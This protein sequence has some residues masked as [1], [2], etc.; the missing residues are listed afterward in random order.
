MKNILK[1]VWLTSLSVVLLTAGMNSNEVLF[2]PWGEQENEVKHEAYPGLHNGP[3]SFQVNGDDIYILDSENKMIKSFNNNSYKASMKIEDPFILDFY[4]DVDKVYLMQQDQVYVIDN[5]KKEQIAKL[6]DS[7]RMYLGLINDRGNIVVKNAEAK[8][9]LTSNILAKRS[10]TDVSVTR[11]LPSS[12]K[13]NIAGNEFVYDLGE[14]GSVDVIG[15]T[16]QGINYI[17]AESIIESSPLKVQRYILLIDNKGKLLQ[18]LELPRQKY[19]YVFKEFF[20]GQEG[21]L[22]HMHSAKDGIHII[23]WDYYAGGDNLSTYSK[24]FN[25]EY[26]FNDFV[27]AEPE[28]SVA[29][30]LNKSA[31]TSVSRT[32]A[33]VTAD[34]YVQH[35]WTATA[36]NIGTTSIVTTPTWIK[37]GQNQKVPYKWGGYNTVAE[38]DIGIAAGKLAGDMNTSAGVDWS[39]C[40]GAD[41]SGFVGVC[42]ET[43]SRYTTSTFNQVTTELA[44]FN[45]LLPADATNNAGSHIRMV[46]EWTDQGKLTQIEETG[47]GWAARY[48]TWNISDLSSYKP[49]RYNSIQNTNAPK[50]NLATIQSMGDSVRI[51]WEADEN[52]VFEGYKIFRKAKNETDYAEIADIPKGTMD[53]LIAQPLNIQYDYYVGSYDVAGSGNYNVSDIYSSKNIGSDFK[54]LIVDGFDRMGS[55]LSDTHRF[56]AQTADAMDSWSVSYDACSNE[57]VIYSQIEISDYDMLWWILGDESTTDQT[58]NATEQTLVKEYL[59]QGGKLFVSGSEIGWDLDYKG[60]TNEKAFFNDYLKATFVADNAESYNVIG[61]SGTDFSHLNFKFSKDGVESDTYAEDYPD[62]LSTSG[63]SQGV[64]KYANSKT[65]AVAYSGAFPDGTKD[66]KVMVM[67]FPFEVIITDLQ[68]ELL[69]GEILKYM[70]HDSGVA[71]EET[72]PESFVLKQNYP[73]PFNPMTTIEYSLNNSAD[74]AILV[75]NIK[76]DLVRK[77]DMGY[78]SQGLHSIIFDGTKLA[79]GV[80]VYRLDINN[81]AMDAGKMVLSK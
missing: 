36:D 73:N 18:T 52:E 57:A 4:K 30:S 20:I 77:F 12:L 26:Y 25:E 72:L 27:E 13:L 56:S 21:E 44:S 16:E 64:L 78:Q 45:S 48:Y 66:G 24:E 80:Y 2:V 49:I 35:I 42:W 33:L 62:V 51:R 22:Y 23:R 50:P 34:E 75:Y 41:C 8:I 53:T 38:F 54:V 69:A 17:Y 29:P 68:R 40:V 81:K 1:I 47:S 67:G 7:K 74:V 15:S 6:K 79:S 59:K 46:V 19:T 65:A 5:G 55:Y 11:E 14:I 28:I 58:F 60:T 37:I 71:I 32:T 9:N 3:M 10:M 63:G 31:A 43:S 39:G 70:G 76:G 61:F